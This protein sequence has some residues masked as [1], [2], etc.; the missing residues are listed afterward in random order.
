MQPFCDIMETFDQTDKRTIDN[1][2]TAPAIATES[3]IAVD[4]NITAA[5][6]AFLVG[7]AEIDYHS[8]PYNDDPIQDYGWMWQYCS[9]YGYYQ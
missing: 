7:I 6:H 1:G 5:W 2:G 9:H 4:H 8:I 3:G